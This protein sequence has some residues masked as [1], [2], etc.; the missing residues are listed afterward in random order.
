MP[1]PAGFP[2]GFS[3]V[4]VVNARSGHRLSRNATNTATIASQAVLGFSRTVR[5]TVDGT[6]RSRGWVAALAPS[7]MRVGGPRTERA[8]GGNG[9]V[10]MGDSMVSRPRDTV[11]YWSDRWRRAT[12]RVDSGSRPRAPIVLDMSEDLVKKFW[13]GQ[14][15][16]TPSSLTHVY[17][18]LN[19]FI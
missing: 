15:F 4:V 16:L 13:G 8:H 2:P 9:A 12:E 14:N 17:N 18:K 7:V 10:T 3:D 11:H 19:L 6:E 5:R 1:R